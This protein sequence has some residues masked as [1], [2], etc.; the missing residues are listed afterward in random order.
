MEPKMV[1][2]KRGAKLVHALK[3]YRSSFKDFSTLCGHTLRKS[4][5]N[6]R[7]RENDGLFPIN[8]KRCLMAMTHK[9]GGDQGLKN[10]IND[11][12]DGNNTRMTGI[13]SDMVYN[14]IDNQRPSH[15]ICNGPG[16]RDLCAYHF[17][18]MNL[19][20][21]I[22]YFMRLKDKLPQIE[23]W[24]GNRKSSSDQYFLDAGCGP[25]NIMVTAKAVGLCTHHHG[26]EYFDETYAQAEQWL[27]LS[28]KE[29]STYKLFK[30]DVLTFKDY[31]KYDIVYFYCPFE[32]T[33]LQMRFEERL[34]DEMKVGAVLSGHMKQSRAIRKDYRFEHINGIGLYGETFIKVKNGPR[35]N[36]Q[37]IEYSY[38]KCSRKSVIKLYHEK[39]N[40]VS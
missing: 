2:V 10:N 27:G 39:Y 33:G 11:E 30:D 9:D 20:T 31:K 37:A 35:K 32:D 36:S 13:L 1:L 6:Y 7:A 40:L 23:N 4:D 3:C 18:P 28:R 29:W 8:C 38:K 22:K 5:G 21:N 15:D 19:I 25:G 34:E 17:I 16:Y 24:S 14:L 12:T 26:I